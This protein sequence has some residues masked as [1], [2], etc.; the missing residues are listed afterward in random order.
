MHGGLQVSG[1]FGLTRDVQ[2]RDIPN[3][4]ASHAVIPYRERTAPILPQN[5]QIDRR[6]WPIISLG[7]LPDSDRSLIWN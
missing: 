2:L 4:Q 7:A 5:L 6:R 3:S 1:I